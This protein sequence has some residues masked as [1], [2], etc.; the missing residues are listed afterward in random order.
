MPLRCGRVFVE[1]VTSLPSY[2]QA[3]TQ[4]SKIERS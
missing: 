3:D 1:S 2:T 4:N